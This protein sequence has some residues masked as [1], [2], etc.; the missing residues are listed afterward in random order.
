MS[1]R[2]VA[3]VSL[4]VCA[5]FSA[6]AAGDTD[7]PQ[8]LTFA[9]VPQ[10]SASKLARTWAPI[11]EYLERETGL[12]LEF[13]T[14]PDIPEFE[15]RIAAGEDDFAY[16]NPLHY[17]V[18]S[19]TPGYRAFAKARD[20][21]IKGIL[22]VRKDS[23]ISSPRDLDG[24]TLAFP[25][26]GAFAA[27]VLTR[28]YLAGEGIGF[29]PQYVS[30]HDS[31]YRTVA[32]GLYP[33][34]GGVQRTFNSMEADIRDQLR[35]L[36]TTR[37]YTPHAFAAHPRVPPETVERL[38]QAMVRMEQHEAGRALLKSLSVRGFETAEDS[39]WDDVRSLGIQ[40]SKDTIPA[41][42]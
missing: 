34:G 25:A 1:T 16:M 33:A 20:K 5:V 3:L 37:G 4:L 38:A 14:A 22:V 17:T 15:T 7:V 18:F 8:G 29:T 40:S 27:S 32:K 31:V 36:W 35:V 6:E 13:R 42:R 12:N 9:I 26:P 41:P 2:L 28:A 10:Q 23:P 39:D 24:A 11:L 21:R 19:E 30:S